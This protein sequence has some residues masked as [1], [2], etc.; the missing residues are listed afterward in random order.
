MSGR[1]SDYMLLDRLRQD[2]DYYLGNGNRHPK[3]LWAGDEKKQIEKMIELYNSFTEEEK[4]EW[5]DLDDIKDY[6]KEMNVPVIENS[7]MYDSEYGKVYCLE[8]NMNKDGVEFALLQKDKKYII[9]CGVT[10][11]DELNLSWKQSIFRDNLMSANA[12][13]E[14]LAL[15]PS[16]KIENTMEAFKDIEPFIFF[17]AVVEYEQD[18]AKTE[19]TRNDLKT[20]DIIYDEFISNDEIHLLSEEVRDL[21]EDYNY[22][23]IANDIREY[24]EEQG[25]DKIQISLDDIDEMIDDV[26]EESITDGTDPSSLIWIE[27]YLDG[28]VDEYL[29]NNEEEEDER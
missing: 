13:Y 8:N 3:H 17:S 20:L 14:K 11:D 6:A 18:E 28:K 22:N 24:L 9:A 12:V 26:I 27:G 5:I 21:E 15:T 25:V 23:R 2:C 10:I 19:I 16:K 7:K 4:P 1:E 29:N